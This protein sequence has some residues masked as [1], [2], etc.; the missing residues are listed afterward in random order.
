MNLA[1]KVTHVPGTSP[2][3]ASLAL[4]PQVFEHVSQR[5]QVP[6]VLHFSGDDV[7][8]GDARYRA[9]APDGHHIVDGPLPPA[10]P[11][12]YRFLLDALAEGGTL[13]GKFGMERGKHIAHRVPGAL[14]ALEEHLLG[15]LAEKTAHPPVHGLLLGSSHVGA[16][17]TVA[18][19]DQLAVDVAVIG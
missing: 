9:A 12:S 10:H 2:L 8:A 3:P 14:I 19:V 11:G 1:M 5:I 16:E 7:Y 17:D 4:G 18:A 13:L 15:K 6:A